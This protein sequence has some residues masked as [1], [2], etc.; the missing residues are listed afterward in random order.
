MGVH[1]VP[2]GQES[3]VA[4]APALA[5]PNAAVHAV[6]E[7]PLQPG[8]KSR[9]WI[10]APLHWYSEPMTFAAHA[11]PVGRR[12]CSVVSQHTPAVQHPGWS[13]NVQRPT[14]MLHRPTLQSTPAF[15]QSLSDWQQPGCLVPLQSPADVQMSLN[16]HAL[17]S[18]QRVPGLADHALGLLPGTHNWH[19]LF[20]FV[21]E[22]SVHAP[23][24]KHQPGSNSGTHWP[25]VGSHEATWQAFGPGHVTAVLAQLPVPRSH[26]SVVHRLP[27]SQSPSLLQ[28]PGILTMTQA[29]NVT[30]HVGLSHAPLAVQSES[31]LQQPDNWL[32]LS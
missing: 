1:C 5:V 17:P 6:A 15:V 4:Q 14:A 32:Q 28:Q 8:V 20:G 26:V 30:S 13:L 25:V 21:L 22:L 27:S 16:V 9:F 2:A 23:S 19:G 29:P 18:S 11:V 31:S 12:R 10:S 24:M 7:L 3:M